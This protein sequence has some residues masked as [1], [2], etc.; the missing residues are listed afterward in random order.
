MKVTTFKTKKYKGC[1]IYFRNF[2]NHFEY[3]TIIK[4]ELYTAHISVRPH[5]LTKLFFV[6]D[7]TTGVDKIPYSAQQLANIIRAL[8]KM[9]E[10]TIETMFA[11]DKK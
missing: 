2:K 4:G 8:T 1:P 3:L 6:L 10:T 7:I 5:W 9:A 11:K